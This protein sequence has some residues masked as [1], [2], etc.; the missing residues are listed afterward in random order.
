VIADA[1]GM[2][3]MELYLNFDRPLTEKE[4]E[5]CRTRI[6]RRG[7]GE[8]AQYIQGT[9]EFYD[10]KIKVTPDVLIP[11]QETEIL[12]DIIAKKL[13]GVNLEGKV[14]WD[15]CCGSG[16][17]GI[18]LKK[19]FPELRV[20]LSDIS[21]KALEVAKENAQNNQVKVDFLE[22]DL[23]KPFG[24]AKTHFFVCNPPYISEN[25]YPNLDPEV[26]DFEPKLALT[27]GPSGLD[28]YKRLLQELPQHLH[29]DAI[30]WFEIG[31]G[32]GNEVAQLFSSYH[33]V[34][35][36]DWAGHDRYISF[37]FP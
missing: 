18:A 33:P 37:V 2:N 23:L 9:V 16:A 25:A 1:L 14:L 13:E 29:H 6:G 11:R 8:P 34:V 12:V 36:Q 22:G 10:C 17:I 21:S 15:V 32:Q 28:F 26:R 24:D 19:K 20:V 27:G 31:T 7:K 3:R 4:I 30:V 5:E 35:L